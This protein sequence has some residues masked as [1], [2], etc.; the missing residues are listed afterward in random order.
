VTLLA[1]ALGVAVSA[2][3]SF[4]A[5]IFS[6]TIDSSAVSGQAAGV[7]FDFFAS[8]TP[9]PNSVFIL[10]FESDGTMGLLES[11][12]GLVEGDLVLG[13]NPA[14]FT[15]IGGTESFNEALVP[16]SPFGSQTTF[17][18]SFTDIPAMPG[19]IP[20]SF[21]FYI[22]DAAGLPLFPTGDPL[23]ANALFTFDFTGTGNLAV[24]G[25]AS[26]LGTDIL[27]TVPSPDG[28][29]IP[30]PATLLLVGSGAVAVLAHR[31]RLL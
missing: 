13:L 6:V 16:L 15:S 31:R 5:S 20:D 8:S 23:G 22:L 2:S 30:E 1:V 25:P 14:P 12:G 17:T 24:F 3:S 21:A 4:A 27:I 19:G 10:D 9:S 18:L 28:T 7:A 11:Q 29:V 26:L